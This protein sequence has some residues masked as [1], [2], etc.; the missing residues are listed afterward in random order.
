MVLVEQ[1][2]EH[3]LSVPVGNIA[4][5]ERGPPVCFDGLNVNDISFALFIVNRSFIPRIL[6]APIAS[7]IVGLLA[8]LEKVPSGRARR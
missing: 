1:L 3:V 7:S 4:N 6:F 8:G 2:Q 5:H